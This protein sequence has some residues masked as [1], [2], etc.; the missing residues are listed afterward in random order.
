MDFIYK[1]YYL[2]L[3]AFKEAGYVFI[4]VKQF[5]EGNLPQKFIILRNDVERRYMNAFKL[6]QMQNKLGI[7]A[8]YF[9]RI[10]KKYFISDVVK[11]IAEKN[12]EIGYHYDDFVSC[13]ADYD[14]A[15]K[16][17]QNN[18]SEL[19]KYSDVS[20]ISMEGSPLSKYE[21]KKLWTKFKHQDLGIETDVDI[22][23][24]FNDVFYITDTGRRW[25][26]YNVSV[27]D[28]VVSRQKIWDEMGYNYHS[29]FDIIDAIGNNSF[30]DKAIITFH[31]QRWNDNL[32]LW[33]SQLIFQ[34]FKNIFKWIL[35]KFK[36]K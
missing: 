2:L 8:T 20:S 17:F 30:P 27:R 35:I 4:T 32:L 1:T 15:I 7:K 16:R 34:N 24:D 14:K 12:H 33:L 11:Q 5:S 3:T 29:S 6:S 31:P 9:F 21:N 19:R 22:D 23:I 13:N 36:N 28:K 10:N 26:G 18:I 25:N